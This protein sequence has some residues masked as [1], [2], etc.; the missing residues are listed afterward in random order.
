MLKLITFA[1]YEEKNCGNYVFIP[2]L[3]CIPQ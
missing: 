2:V 1:K 3:L